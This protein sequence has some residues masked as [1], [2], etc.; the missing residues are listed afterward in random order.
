MLEPP[1][2]D[3]RTSLSD[4]LDGAVTKKVMSAD[5]VEREHVDDAADE[6][7]SRQQVRALLSLPRC[8]LGLM[9]KR[10]I[11]LPRAAPRPV[12]HVAR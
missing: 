12:R 3:D 11:E 5:G 6:E 10:P 9:T 2:G 1:P 8:N 7:A 4:V